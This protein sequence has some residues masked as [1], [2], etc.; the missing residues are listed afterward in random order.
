MMLSVRID[1]WLWATRM[2]KTRSLATKACAAGHVKVNGK[3]VKASHALKLGVMV[4]ALTPGGPKK[5]E[6]LALSDKRQA[7]VIAKELY[8]D[9]SPPPDSS[10]M[11]P[12]FERGGRPSKKDRRALRRLK[13][14]Q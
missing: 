5:L 7:Y 6:V 13:G 4:D 14:F 9:H 11:A 10:P 3:A 1:K 8:V 12:R 2:Y